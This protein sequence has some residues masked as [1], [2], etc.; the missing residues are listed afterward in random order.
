MSHEHDVA[1]W[2]SVHIDGVSAICQAICDEAGAVMVGELSV[3]SCG[4]AQLGPERSH[5][6]II[7]ACTGKHNPLASTKRYWPA[8]P[9]RG[10]FKDGV[11]ENN[12]S[13]EHL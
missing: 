7:W 11:P 4:I 9:S 2:H 12:S 3:E 13:R 8:C 10:L 1:P 6:D 5:L